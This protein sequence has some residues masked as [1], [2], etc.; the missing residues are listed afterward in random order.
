M[1][2]KRL[3]QRSLVPR[4]SEDSIESLGDQYT[5]LLCL[6]AAGT[7]LLMVAT[8]FTGG[9][10]QEIWEMIFL[11]ITGPCYLI[12]RFR[13]V[14]P[15]Q[16]I[17]LSRRIS[18]V[19]TFSGCVRWLAIWAFPQ[20]ETTYINIVS[21]LLYLPLLL[22]CLVLIGANK[23]SINLLIACYSI[24][25]IV[26][27]HQ[28]ALQGTPFEDWRL[29]PSI[30][31]AYLVFK[32][33][34]GS[35]LTLNR[36]VRRLSIDNSEL[37][38]SST[39]DPLT[40]AYNRRG[41]ERRKSIAEASQSGVIMLD[42]DHFK[43]FNDDYGHIAGD[44]VLTRISQCL[45]SRIRDQDSVCRWGGEEFLIL[46][47]LGE[48][49]DPRAILHSISNGLLH[50]I[51][52]LDLSDISKDLGVTA[53]AGICLMDS[54]DSFQASIDLADQGLLQA[55]RRGRDQVASVQWDINATSGQKVVPLNP[56]LTEN[57]AI[58]EG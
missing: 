12:W 38:T 52:A 41:L 36:S 47:N 21:G 53:S 14:D 20:I 22:G 5:G 24:T 32:Q 10:R 7:H 8:G 30:A 29:G 13:C 19:L 46:V 44:K 54:E 17:R 33:L 15:K 42:I 28:E 2:L 50:S 40:N 11:T 4:F 57:G 56:Q 45:Q 3:F 18:T 31:A 25:P 34:L 16:H 1:A 51:R 6:L 58:L 48:T 49:Q 43:R 37:E 23:T 55:K 9:G 26:F 27:T 35:V 39:R